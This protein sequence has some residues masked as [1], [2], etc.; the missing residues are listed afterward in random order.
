MIKVVAESLERRARLDRL[1]VR[2]PYAARDN[3]RVA[4]VLFEK[5]VRL[6]VQRIRGDIPD[7]LIDADNLA[8]GFGRRSRVLQLD[9]ENGVAIDRA[10]ID[11]AAERDGQ[12][13]LQVEAIQRVDDGD[14]VV[15][16]GPRG[17]VRQW[18]IDSAAGALTEVGHGEPIA[19]ERTALRSC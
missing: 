15:V 9:Q 5:F 13:R 8:A 7:R 12:S 17:T 1:S 18:Q 14:V 6:D 10:H 2:V 19:R 4:R 16:R 3:E 11:G